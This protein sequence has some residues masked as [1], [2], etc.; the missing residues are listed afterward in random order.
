MGIRARA[1][2]LGVLVALA[3]IVTAFGTAGAGAAPGAAQYAVGPVADLTTSCSGQ[4]AEVEQASDPAR[5]LVFEAWMGCSGIAFSRS[6]DGGATFS[7]P[8]SVPGSVGSNYNAWDPA[9]TVAPDGTVYVAF[10]LGHGGQ[11][12]PVVAT[13]FDHGA[14]FPQVAELVP[15]DPKNWG[16]REFLAVAPDGTV[17][18]TYDYGPNRT[19][20]TF[21]CAADG[22]CGYAS[23]DVNVVMQKSTDRGKSFGPMTYV[24]PGFPASGGDLAPLVVEPSGRIDALYQGYGITDTTTYAMTPAYEY[25]TSST[26]GGATWSTPLKVGA[27]AGTMSLA[28]WWIDADIAIDGAGNLY[29][30]WDTQGTNPD[31][32]AND[33]G[34]IATSTDHGAHWSKPIQGPTDTL[35]VPHVMQVTAGPAGIAYVGWLSDSDPRGYAM[36]LRTYSLKS[37]WLGAAQQVSTEFGDPSVW[38]GDTFGIST[39]SPTDVVLSWG[40][41][42]PSVGNKKSDIFATHV[43]VRLP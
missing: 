16:D 10:M 11:W 12:Y 42:T 13:S 43:T 30:T 33:T 20:I 17:Y 32:S 24:S 38:P 18:L 36:F 21:L 39:L 31:G 40:S 7:T 3:G 6:A 5:Q 4:N 34:W 2:R 15:P 23:G 19:S 35:A 27:S 14:T 37:G 22:S 41:A 8:I 1:R 26:D 28:E 9:V 29:A 25:F